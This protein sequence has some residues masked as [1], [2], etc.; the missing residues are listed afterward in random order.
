MDGSAMNIDYLR[1]LKA[2]SRLTNEQLAQISGIPGSTLARIFNGRTD[3]PYF[4]TIVDLVR[5]MK[6]SVDEM[7]G[8]QPLPKDTNAAENAAVD[9]KLITQYREIINNKERLIRLLAGVLLAVMIFILIMVT[10]DIL[11]PM[12]GWIQH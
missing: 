2:E 8:L 11:H 10:Y 9:K 1:K 6:G 12:K 3:N 4:H 7:E 5:A